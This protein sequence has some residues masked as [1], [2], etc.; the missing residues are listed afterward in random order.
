V[1]GESLEDWEILGFCMLLLV[2]GND[3]T[4]Y[5]MGNMLNLL[6]ERPELWQQLRADR[7][8]VE[9]VIEE[10]LR[11]A[12]PVQRFYRVT[13]REVSFAGA[14]MAKGALVAFSGCLS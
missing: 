5:L 14:T 10:A 1:E 6:A 7:S 2:A 13:T 11:Y 9:P 3:T 8:V 12:S 4:T